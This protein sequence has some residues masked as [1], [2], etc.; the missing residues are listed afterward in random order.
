MSSHGW[1]QQSNVKSI[2]SMAGTPRRANGVWSSRTSSCVASGN[3]PPAPTF[4]AAARRV[5]AQRVFPPGTVGQVL[6]DH[7]P[8]AR[9]GVPSIDLIDFTFDCWHRPCD[10]LDVVS[11][12][13]L[14]LTG[15]TVYELVRTLRRR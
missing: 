8:F 10:Y 9:R 6:D 15:E 11:A 3:T 2:R 14:D 12:R 13:S 4:F 1:C 5:G 7:T